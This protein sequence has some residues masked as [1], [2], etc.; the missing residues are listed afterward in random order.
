MFRKS[1]D[2]LLLNLFKSGSTL[3]LKISRRSSEIEAKICST[4]LFG[5]SDA[6][7]SVHPGVVKFFCFAGSRFYLGKKRYGGFG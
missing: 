6:A 1:R 5:S 4:E 2:E 7:L 3:V